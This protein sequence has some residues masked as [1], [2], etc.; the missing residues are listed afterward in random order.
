MAE[1]PT[2]KATTRLFAASISRL[3]FSSDW[4]EFNRKQPRCKPC[5]KITSHGAKTN[6]AAE[7]LQAMFEV[8]YFPPNTPSSLKPPID[9][10]LRFPHFD[11]QAFYVADDFIESQDH[12]VI[13]IFLREL[14]PHHLEQIF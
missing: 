7:L 6:T 13:D 11:I 4:P 9:R 8:G 5:C 12:G 1:S 3:L 10:P 2:A 14:P